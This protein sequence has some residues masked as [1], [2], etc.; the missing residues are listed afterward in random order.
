MIIG[1]IQASSQTSKNQILYELTREAAKPHEVV[2]FG[3]FESEEET[4]SYVEI[5]VEI[6]L[7]L[8]SGAVDFAVTGCSSGQG[9]ML[10][11]NSMPEVICGYAPTPQ[12]AFLFGRINA[13]NAVSVP[14]GLNYGWSGELNLRYTLA[15]LFEQP[16]GTGYPPED[17]QRKQKDT[18]LLKSILSASRTSMTGLLNGLDEAFCAKVLKKQNVIEFI[19]SHG[20]EQ[21]LIRWIKDRMDADAKP[22]LCLLEETLK[23]KEAT[24][25]GKKEGTA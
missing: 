7:L 14:L 4:Y 15:A 18:R 3:C 19:L 24:A 8:A 13:G 6:G 1:V 11:C 16:F 2:N 5:A 23:T 17:A 20:K 21:E 12:D 25:D 9:M 22:A 10:A